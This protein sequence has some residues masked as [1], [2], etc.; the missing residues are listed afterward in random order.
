M[1]HH[2]WN[3]L[4][5]SA[6]SAAVA[7]VVAAPALAQNTTAAI[8]G[9]VVDGNGKA[10]AGAS[11]SIL[12]TESGSTSNTTT[13]ADGRYAARG[14][15]VGGPYTITIRQG[16]QTETRSGVVLALAETLTLDA[17]LGNATVVVTGQA[18]SQTFSRSNMGAGTNLSN[19]Q[20]NALPSIQRNLQD[21]ART[22]PRI[23]QTDK[24]RGEISALGQN[25][26]FNSITIDGVNTNDPFGLESNNLPTLKQP[27]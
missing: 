27:I 16:G 8:G 14:L 13:D 1:R 24:D 4:A 15:R 17:T 19:A 21:Y 23:A 26:R 10:V 18:L 5:R 25:S 12:H 7:I 22:D 3:S 20:I 11:V 9:R 6:L 2:P